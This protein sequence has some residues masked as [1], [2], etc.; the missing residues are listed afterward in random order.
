ERRAADQL[1]TQREHRVPKQVVFARIM[2]V[3][4]GRRDPD[5]RRDRLHAHRVIAEPAERLGR[6][7]SDLRLAILG[8]SPDAG[9][10]GRPAA[11]HGDTL[12]E[13]THTYRPTSIAKY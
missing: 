1:L 9:I 8:P 7:P 2:P 5:P 10:G 11:R 12:M 3:Q 6:R 13:F 4:R